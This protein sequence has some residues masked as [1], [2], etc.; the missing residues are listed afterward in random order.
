MPVSVCTFDS[1]IYSTDI[2]IELL[3]KGATIV[4]LLRNVATLENDPAF[5]PYIESGKAKFHKGDATNYDDVLAGWKL[6]TSEGPVDLILY[7]V[8]AYLFIYIYIFQSLTYFTGG[9]EGGFHPIKGVTMAQP[10]ICSVSIVN[11]LRAALTTQSSNPPKVIVLSSI[12][13]TPQ[14][15]RTLPLVLGVFYSYLLRIPFADKRG[16]EAVLHRAIGTPYEEG[17]TPDHTILP[18]G[19]K[20]QVPEGSFAKHGNGGGGVV[21]RAARLTDDAETGKYRA[22]KG[23]F[24]TSTISRKDVG[25][26]VAGDLLEN[27]SK[28]EGGVVTIGY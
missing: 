19:W 26:F 15:R 7:T 9:T 2:E 16:L 5:K 13:T 25:H 21:I 17:Q 22:E 1:A 10:D 12:G 18:S 24:K 27:W 11:T 3:A 20:E 23:D 28:Y 14:S 8:G 6:A 4:Y